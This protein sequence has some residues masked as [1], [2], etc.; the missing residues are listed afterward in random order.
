MGILVL[1]PCSKDKRFDPVLNCGAVDERS[2]EEL[3]RKNREYVKTAAE[4]YTGRENQHVKTAVDYLR[5]IANVDWHII[6]AGFGLLC[7]DIK[8][9]SYEC[10]FS[11]IDKQFHSPSRF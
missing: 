3:I 1:S 8:I 7:E 4:M 2:R 6:S 5:E 10:D 11:D 9:P